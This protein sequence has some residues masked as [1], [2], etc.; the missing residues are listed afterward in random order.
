MSEL[1]VQLSRI[2][3]AFYVLLIHVYSISELS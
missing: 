3:H 1:N 2:L